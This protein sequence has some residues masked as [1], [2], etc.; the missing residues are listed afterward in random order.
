[1]DDEEEAPPA[2][3]K[4]PTLALFLGLYLILLAFFVLL[5][6]MATP[7]E[8]RVKAVLSSLLSTFSTE[9]L[10]T[11]NPT[12]FTASVGEVLATEEYH[13][14]IKDFFEV[15]IPLSRVEFFS[16]GAAMRIVMPADQLFEPASI[17]IRADREDLMRRIVTSLKRRVMGMRYEMEFT[18]FT[19]PVVAQDTAASQ[20][21][22]V[23]RAGA[24]ARAMEDRDVPADTLVI[25]AQPGNPEEV[26]F[27][28][29]VRVEDGAKV[30][31]ER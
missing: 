1:M 13:R 30:T 24:L 8:D 20:I 9:I 19:G 12:E 23:A 6:T 27:T 31:F 5:N 28:F 14:E 16:A 7:K 17:R 15:A 25:G 11:I 4:D 3:P 18:T 21:I 10:N 26:E 29:T 22:E 2:V